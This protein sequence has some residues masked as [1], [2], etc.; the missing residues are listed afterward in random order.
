MTAGNPNGVA[1]INGMMEPELLCDSV[2]EALREETFLI[3]P[4][5]DVLTYMLRKTGG[6]DRWLKGMRRLQEGYG[7]PD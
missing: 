4:H 2:V 1:S 6:Y 3:L 5:P 7:K